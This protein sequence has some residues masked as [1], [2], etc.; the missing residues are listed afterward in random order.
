ME[1][2]TI[3]QKTV[4]RVSKDGKPSRRSM[5][6]WCQFNYWYRNLWEAEGRRPTVVEVKRWYEEAADSCWGDQ[7]PTWEETR[8]HS[9]CLRSLD[10]VRTYFRQYRAARKEASKS[11]IT[12]SAYANTGLLQQDLSNLPSVSHENGAATNTVFFRDAKLRR[13]STTNSDVSTVTMLVNHSQEHAPSLRVANT[14][15][16]SGFV[17]GANESGVPLSGVAF[18]QSCVGTWS[19][20]ISTGAV[21]QGPGQTR[22]NC[23]T[24]SQTGVRVECGDAGAR[25]QPSSLVYAGT[26]DANALSI[27]VS[28]DGTPGVWLHQQPS[29]APPSSNSHQQAGTS[30]QQQQLTQQLP[31]P[32]PPAQQQ[33]A[34]YHAALQGSRVNDNEVPAQ[35]QAV[36]RSIPIDARTSS[37]QRVDLP[38]WP[39]TSPQPQPHPVSGPPGARPSAAATLPGDHFPPALQQAGA[40]EAAGPLKVAMI[41]LALSAGTRATD[42]ISER[43]RPHA[44][45]LTHAPGNCF[46]VSGA[47]PNHRQQQQAPAAAASQAAGPVLTHELPAYQHIHHV[48]VHHPMAYMGYDPM[49]GHPA[50]MD[51]YAYSYGMHDP[52]AAA[53]WRM[54]PYWYA[55]AH[56]L[57]PELGPHMPS[58]RNF[59]DGSI[60]MQ[61]MPQCPQQSAAAAAVPLPPQQATVKNCVTHPTT[62]THHAGVLQ[63]QVERSISTFELARCASVPLLQQPNIPTSVSVDATSA[64]DTAVRSSGTVPVPTQPVSPFPLQCPVYTTGAGNLQPNL[65]DNLQPGSGSAL[66]PAAGERRRSKGCRV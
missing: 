5:D 45:I 7:K 26:G 11:D 15:G 61:A 23:A 8:S 37:P 43:Q 14:S 25:P 41:G 3:D 38:V 60:P 54:Y 10:Q 12:R 2:P 27:P 57:Y 47:N 17:M 34:Y 21:S 30:W 65:P 51:P 1:A 16:L 24:A 63:H 48:P 22:F 31:Q 13:A 66:S 53:Y 33:G 42:V 50:Y 28:A 36:L 20:T 40:R 44:G 9:K 6:F 39:L 59:C 29:D 58:Y 62:T 52:S 46:D 19:R 64:C 55:T 56:T 4:K 18:T 32:I 35:P 49:L